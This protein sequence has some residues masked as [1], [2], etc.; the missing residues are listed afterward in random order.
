MIPQWRCTSCDAK[1]G[2]GAPLKMCP[3]CGKVGTLVRY[4]GNDVE[5]PKPKT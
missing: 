2:S 4:T 3:E 1:I 5:Q